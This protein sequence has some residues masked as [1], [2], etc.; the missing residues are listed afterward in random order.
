[1]RIAKA[2]PK[3]SSFN[4]IIIFSR[5]WCS[6]SVSYI[7]FALSADNFGIV[8]SKEGFSSILEIAFSPSRSTID[9]AVFLPIPLN[10]SLDKY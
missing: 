6:T 9:S 10:R 5:P 4:P 2:A 3:P 1:M 7:V 8:S